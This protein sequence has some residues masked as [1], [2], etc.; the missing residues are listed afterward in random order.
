[1]ACHR[2]QP[3]Q[4]HDFSGQRSSQAFDALTLQ[5]DGLGHVGGRRFNQDELVHGPE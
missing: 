4:L 5:A 3:F 1:M 2:Q